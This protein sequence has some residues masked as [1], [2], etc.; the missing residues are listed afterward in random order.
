MDEEE[1][2]YENNGGVVSSSPSK[3]NLKYKPNQPKTQTGKDIVGNTAL[4]AGK[5]T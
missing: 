4:A 5:V 1:L 3:R 2:F